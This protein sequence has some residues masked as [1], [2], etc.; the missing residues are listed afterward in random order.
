MKQTFSSRMRWRKGV[1]RAAYV[2][3]YIFLGGSAAFAQGAGGNERAADL[4]AKT[5]KQL[6]A[7][8]AG[9]DGVMGLATKDLTSG[10]SFV[11]NPDMVFPQ[12]SAIKIPVLVELFRQAQTGTLKL[13]EKVD[14]KKSVM[15]GGSGVLGRFSDGGSAISLRDLAVLMIVL[16]DNTATNILI[17]RVGMQS[18]NDLLARNNLRQ[19]RLQRKMIDTESQK[20]GKENLSTP[21]EMIWLLGLLH[22]GKLLDAA[23]T[24]SVL[25]IL[26]YSKD[27]PLR[28]SLPAT[29]ELASK[30]GSLAGVSCESGIVLLA[31][32]PYAIAV[33]TTYAAPGT[34]GSDAITEAS[35]VVYAYFERMARANP[36]GARLP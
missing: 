34:S 36:L 1:I 35:R 13:D 14:V 5:Q 25:E 8:V 26:K 9:F 20:A 19:S 10:E 22:Q 21:A 16:S 4:R 30:T 6:E 11:V 31:G 12:A 3:L 33:M 28:R 29:V 24:A 7:I 17:D 27:T 2:G 18:V 23:H 32:R 15:V